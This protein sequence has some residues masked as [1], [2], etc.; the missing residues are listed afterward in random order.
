[1]K[2]LKQQY[3]TKSGRAY[4]SEW[5]LIYDTNLSYFNS[6][7][8]IN[9]LTIWDGLIKPL[10]L[11]RWVALFFLPFVYV[12]IAAIGT[13]QMEMPIA[14]FAVV[15]FLSSIL[16]MLAYENELGMVGRLTFFWGLSAP[17]VIALSPILAIFIMGGNNHFNLGAKSKWID[18]V[19]ND[20]MRKATSGRNEYHKL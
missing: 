2:N 11:S 12:V 1:M 5:E 20:T 4:P 18:H 15:G 3:V 10:G 14:M 16:C 8:I 7:L 13:K 19:T 6:L 9:T 17:L